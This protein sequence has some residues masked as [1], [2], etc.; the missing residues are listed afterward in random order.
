[1]YCMYVYIQCMQLELPRRNSYKQQLLWTKHST[2]W[3]PGMLTKLLMA[4]DLL[5]CADFLCLF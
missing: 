3:F 5:F 2:K 1:M 4:P